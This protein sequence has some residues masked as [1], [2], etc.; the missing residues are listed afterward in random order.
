MKKPFKVAEEVFATGYA[1]DFYDNGFYMTEKEKGTIQHINASGLIKVSSKERTFW[2]HERNLR[3]IK[4]KEKTRLWAKKTTNAA[5][6]YLAK[7]SFDDYVTKEPT[8]P[9]NW[10]EFKLVRTK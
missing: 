3:H 5:Q 1:R 10:L 7:I 2:I 8:D 6:V 4:K 9:E